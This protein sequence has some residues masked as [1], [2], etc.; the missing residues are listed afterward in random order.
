MPNTRSNIS[1]G[2][3]VTTTFVGA[4]AFGIGY[5]LGAT[6]F[7]DWWNKGVSSQLDLYCAC[8][9]GH[10]AETMERHPA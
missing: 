10:L 7:W 2:V 9:N 6:A 8:R 4:F 3:F 1:V 5:D